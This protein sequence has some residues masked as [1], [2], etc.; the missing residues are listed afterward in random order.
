[1]KSR[2]RQSDYSCTSVCGPANQQSYIS[3]KHFWDDSYC[4]SCL[5]AAPGSNISG[6]SMTGII[7]GGWKA[8]FFCSLGFPFFISTPGVS[9]GKYIIQRQVCSPRDQYWFMFMEFK[10]SSWFVCLSP[11]L[12]STLIS[13]SV[14]FSHHHP[15]L[16]L[17]WFPSS[18]LS[19]T[20]HYFPLSRFDHCPRISQSLSSFPQSVWMHSPW[21]F[22]LQPNRRTCCSASN[23][24]E[25][26]R[27]KA[28]GCE[29]FAATSP[30]PSAGLMRWVT[31]HSHTTK[32]GGSLSG[33]R[34]A[35]KESAAV[36]KF[37]LVSVS[38]SSSDLRKKHCYTGHFGKKVVAKFGSKNFPL[39]LSDTRYSDVKLRHFKNVIWGLTVHWCGSL[40]SSE[41]VSSS[42][43]VWY[44]GDSTGEDGVK[45][46]VRCH[47]AVMMLR[48]T[49]LSVQR[50]V[51]CR[52]KT[53][54]SVQLT[55]A[56]VTAQY[57]TLILHEGVHVLEVLV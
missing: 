27:L 11:P 12:L 8:G 32:K 1:M 33:H 28:P 16:S 25:R 54:N 13:P 26:R 53:V 56:N 35:G 18:L 47:A 37:G 40:G 42:A 50:S 38:S 6:C 15:S 39:F 20:V 55:K 9:W 49:I 19:V 30:T 4:F 46:P 14:S 31:S 34:Q 36:Y 57:S 29:H 5:K 52:I 43:L 45:C 41:V 24:P 51:W 10:R 7:A 48:T 23:W 2:G 17:S 44:L 21:W 3:L 22:A